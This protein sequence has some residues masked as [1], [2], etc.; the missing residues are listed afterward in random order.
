MTVVYFLR[1]DEGGGLTKIGYSGDPALR[2]RVFQRRLRRPLRLLATIHGGNRLEGRF[3]AYFRAHHSHGEW[4]RPCSEL[5]AV[6]DAI[7]AGSFDIDTLPDV[8]SWM[9][10]E[11]AH[12][13]WAKRRAKL[14]GAAA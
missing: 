9:R 3:H 4:F 8:G 6:I 14:A 7:N 1:D 2:H 11:E 12:R 10:S 5:D 13:T